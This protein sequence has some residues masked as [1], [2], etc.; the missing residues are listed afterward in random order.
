MV[1]RDTLRIETA[2]GVDIDEAGNETRVQEGDFVYVNDKD[3]HQFRGG[4]PLR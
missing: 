2:T 4:V 1:F 3:M